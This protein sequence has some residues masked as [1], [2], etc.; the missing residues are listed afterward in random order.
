MCFPRL[1]DLLLLQLD[2]LIVHEHALALVRVRSAP[3]SDLGGKR[4][5]LFPVDALDEDSRRLGRGDRD[6]EGNTHLDGVGVAQLEEDELLSGVF[7]LCGAGVD[8]GSVTNAD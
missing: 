4:H 1:F 6:A 7:L 8:R 5:D 3:V 2:R